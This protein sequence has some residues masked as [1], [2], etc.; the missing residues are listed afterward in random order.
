M[1]HLDDRTAANLEVVLDQACHELPHGG[2][3]LFR[4]KIARRILGAA[5]QG[6]TTLTS[7]TAI[8]RQAANDALRRKHG[9]RL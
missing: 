5:R 9:S 6:E 3:H 1:K 7:L 8:A 4:K 2:D